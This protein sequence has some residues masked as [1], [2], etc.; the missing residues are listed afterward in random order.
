MLASVFTVVK[1]FIIVIKTVFYGILFLNA[2]I[3]AMTSYPLYAYDQILWVV[4]FWA[5]ELNL[6]E[7]E[8]DRL[9][10]LSEA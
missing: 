7:W 6:A 4:G 2:A 9:K 3:W 1:I 8:Q 10:E 5:I